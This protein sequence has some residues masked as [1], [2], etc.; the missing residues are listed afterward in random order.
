M[1]AHRLAK[2]V[3]L[4]LVAALLLAG[5]RSQS[6]ERRR[7]GSAKGT[8]TKIDLPNNNVSMKI[9]SQKTGKELEVAGILTAETEVWVN[10]VRKGPT[11][12]E[13]NDEIRVE[14]ERTGDELEQKFVVKKVEVTRAEGWKSTRPPAAQPP[15]NASLAMPGATKADLLEADRRTQIAEGGAPPDTPPAIPLTTSTSPADRA[16]QE[17][18]ITDIIY[19]EIRRRL[20][21][22]IG[23]R[24]ALLKAGKP[25]DDPEVV[26]RE[27]I[28]RKAR[29]LLMERGENVEPV[30]PPLPE[31]APATKPAA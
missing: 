14:Y 29:S 3:P 8:V 16:A 5:C 31:D 15:P 12:V 2:F 18:Q 28:I 4:A 26:N 6:K 7:T 21:L 9:L 1:S 17:Q 25:A 30:T 27:N 22:A 13:V 11:D 20:D 19:V 23:E 10:G 24:A